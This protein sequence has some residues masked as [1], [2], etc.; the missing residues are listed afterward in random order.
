MKTKTISFI[1]AGRTDN[2]EQD[3][4]YPLYSTQFNLIEFTLTINI[5]VHEVHILDLQSL[6][7]CLQNMTNTLHI[8][9]HQYHNNLTK[10]SH[11]ENCVVLML[12][13]YWF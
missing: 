10:I 3:R 6:I 13:L 9:K 12:T 11:S 7:K 1:T 8:Y 5:M 2:N 4:P